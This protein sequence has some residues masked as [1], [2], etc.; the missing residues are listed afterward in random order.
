VKGQNIRDLLILVLLSISAFASMISATREQPSLD[1][2]VAGEITRALQNCEFVLTGLELSAWYGY[3]DQL[4]SLKQE[5]EF[6]GRPLENRA[7]IT[8]DCQVSP[9]NIG[10]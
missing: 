7:S 9:F 5:S 6:L 4:S 2:D 8:A 1:L 3:D 10:P